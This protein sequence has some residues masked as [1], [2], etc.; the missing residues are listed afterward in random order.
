M[1]DAPTT[2]YRTAHTD[3]VLT[4]CADSGIEVLQTYEAWNGVVRVNI[5]PL[6]ETWENVNRTLYRR[7]AEHDWMYGVS[8]TAAFAQ[9][10]T[11]LTFRPPEAMR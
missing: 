5:A 3:R 1:T 9:H 7:M 6:L 4:L 2:T 10:A 11:Q 8:H